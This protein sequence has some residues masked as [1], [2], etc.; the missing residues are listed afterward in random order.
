MSDI[1]RRTACSQGKVII[2]VGVVD[3]GEGIY[4]MVT[5]NPKLSVYFV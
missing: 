5:L 3:L 1:K 2:W 4:G